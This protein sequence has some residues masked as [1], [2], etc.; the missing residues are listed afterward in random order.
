[1]FGKSSWRV[2]L[3]AVAITA[4]SMSG[5]LLGQEVGRYSGPGSCAASNCHGSVSPRTAT[6]IKQNEYSIWAAQDK[7]SRAFSV[8]SNA[9]SVRIGKIL[10]LSTSPSQA[11]KCRVCHTLNVSTNLRAQT[12]QGDE[13]VSCEN[14]H[15]PAVGWLGPHTTRGWT[16]EQSVKLGQYDTRDLITRS[17]RC[18][19]CHVGTPEKRVDHQM[20]AAGHPDLT[21]ELD[22]FSAVMPRHWKFPSDNDPWAGVQEWGI[23]QAVQLREAL[24]RLN[25]S[26][27]KGPWP[28]FAEL[29]CF[30][31]HHNLTSPQDSWRQ[32]GGYPGRNPGTPAWNAS[33]Y[34]V[35]RHLV[36]QASA[37]R[38][39]QFNGQLEKVASL[40][41]SGAD[42]NQIAAAAKQASVAADQ[43][44]QQ[45]R[46][47][48]YDRDLSARVMQAIASDA[49]PI[50]EQGE[51]SAEQAAMAIDAICLAYQKNEKIEN[52]AELRAAINRLF[53]LLQN[54]S[55]YNAPMF[56]AQ[57]QK[58]KALLPGA[59]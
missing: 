29:D 23:G 3:C 51:R 8:L 47:Q 22:T 25:R 17:E 57:M 59:K 27:E 52:Q 54:P 18:L 26:A 20:I 6:S 39:Q 11:D 36:E 1:M 49:A 46:K 41:G 24:N 56:A 32:A 2:C 38:G 28:E 4:S 50:S 34:I 55:M 5:S 58:V 7:H 15:G 19:S 31:C 21:F 16:R 53:D 14:C 12:F 35:F 10:K 9:T 13:G 37:D 45:L 42:H 33:R 30:A 40:V 44:A 48:Q 43:I